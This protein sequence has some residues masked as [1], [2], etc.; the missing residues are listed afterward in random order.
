MRIEVLYVSGCPNYLPAR[1]RLCA[2]LHQQG[3]RPEIVEIEILDEF[4]ARSLNFSGSPTI[5]ING[6]DIDPSHSAP[7]ETRFACR[8]YA[9]GLPSEEMIR[10]ALREAQES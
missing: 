10:T 5:R 1:N 8:L 9:G 4:T 3:L 6:V 7:A 2:I